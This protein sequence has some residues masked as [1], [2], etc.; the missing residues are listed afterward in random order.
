MGAMP[1]QWPSAPSA[2]V[3]RRNSLGQVSGSN[4]TF[5]RPTETV[6]VSLSVTKLGQVIA[7]MR[8]RHA[9]GSAT[10]YRRDMG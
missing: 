10:G 7:D 6:S 9:G 5:P 2:L 4:S 8:H 1:S 3:K